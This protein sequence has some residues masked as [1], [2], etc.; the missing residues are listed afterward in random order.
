MG[1]RCSRA[2]AWS[3]CL[4]L[5]S[6]RRRA[7]REDLPGS[8]ASARK[9]CACWIRCRRATACCCFARRPMRRRFCRSPRTTPRCAAPSRACS[10]RAAPPISRAPWKWASA[11]LAGSRR[12]LLVY[13]GPGMID[14][15]QAR[16]PRRISRGT[17]SARRIQRGQPQ[18]LVRLAGDGAAVKNRGITRLSLAPRRRAARSLA[19]AHAAEKLR[20][21]QGGRRAEVFRERPAAR[22]AANRARAA[23]NWPTPKMNLPGTRA[24]CCRRKSLLPTSWTRTIAPSSTLPT[25]RT[26]RVAVFANLV[27][28]FASNLL[29]VLSSNPYVQAQIVPAGNGRERFARCGDLSAAR[30]CRSQPASNSIWFLS[31]PSAANSRPVRVTGWNSQHPVTRWVRTQRRERA[32]SGDAHACCR[33]IPCWPTPMANPPAPLI[34]AREQ[35]GR[36]MLIVGFDPQ[37]SNFPLESAFPL[38]MAGSMEWMTHSV[39]EAAD[40]LSTGELDIPGP[41]TRIVSP[42][43]QGSAVCAQGFGRCICSRWKPEC[44]ASSRPAE[45]PASRSMRPLAARAADDGRARGNGRRREGTASA[46]ELGHVALAGPAGDRRAVA[47]VVAVLRLARTPAER[48]DSRNARAMHVAE[49]GSE[50]DEREESEFAIRKSLRDFVSMSIGSARSGWMT[51]NGRM[52]FDHPIFLLL[53]VL[54]PVLWIWMRRMPGASHVCLALKCAAFAALAIALADPWAP[55]R[56][57]QLAVTVLDGH[58]RQHAA[59]IAA[60]RRSDAA[61][62]GAQEFGRGFAPH[63]VRRSI[64]RS[65]TFPRRPIR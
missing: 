21:R 35:N 31:G 15:E 47:G 24:D 10:P 20:R 56:V 26:V 49:I 36:R 65:A 9:P 16:A 18:F 55:L 34:L 51:G 17:R 50:L 33:A 7:P 38:L 43:G 42:F 59:G 1:I 64:P 8:T 13:V 23:A 6:G 28:A 63:H 25:F 57:E 32:Q 37:D 5:P 45:K 19:L 3:S 22:P 53:L 14:D 58:V 40:S 60:A 2:A 27:L 62:S 39:E 52:T 48:G 11:A 61:R 30:A 4:T 44:I 54:L 46:R 41:V 29:S 12:G